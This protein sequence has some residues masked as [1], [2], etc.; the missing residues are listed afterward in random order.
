MADR[1]RSYSVAPRCC[2]DGGFNAPSSSHTGS[3]QLLPDP[4]STRTHTAR[5]VWLNDARMLMGTKRSSLNYFSARSIHE[6]VFNVTRAVRGASHPEDPLVDT[7][8]RGIRAAPLLNPSTY[9]EI[10]VK[11]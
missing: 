11:K 8:R 1:N 10:C 5:G 6:N 2:A 7:D 9:V 3:L 4:P